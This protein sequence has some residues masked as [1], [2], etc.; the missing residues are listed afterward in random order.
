MQVDNE[1]EK[2]VERNMTV[3]HKVPVIVF[4][5]EVDIKMKT[6][7]ISNICG[8]LYHFTVRGET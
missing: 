6:K 8:S 5:L 7:H 1:R 3:Q 4:F 2:K